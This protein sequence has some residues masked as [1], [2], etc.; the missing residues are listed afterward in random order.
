M[1]NDVSISLTAKD[2]VSAIL[3]QVSKAS[4]STATEIDKL[5][6]S[7]DTLSAAKVDLKTNLVQ[8]QQEAAEARKEFRKLGDS[9]SEQNYKDKLSELEHLEQ[10]YYAVSQSIKIVEKQQSA[11]A[12]SSH[13]KSSDTRKQELSEL[14]KLELQYYALSEGINTVEADEIALAGTRSK[15]YNRTTDGSNAFSTIGSIG[16]A[17]ATAGF[18]QMLSGSLSGAAGA[19]LG[20][21]FGT[22]NGSAVE[23]ILSSALSGASMGA[24]AGSMIGGPGIGTA[25]GAAAGTLIGAVSGGIEAATQ[26]FTEKDEAFKSYVQEQ[27]EGALEAQS[28][29]LTSGSSIA[30]SREQTQMAFAKALGGDEAA[31]AYLDQVREMATR[32]NYTYDEITAYTKQL[33]NSYAPDEI[34]DVLGDLSDA[35]AGLNLNSSDVS[36]W[37]SGLNRMRITDK[38]TLEYLNYFS[39]RGLNVYEALSKALGVQESAVQDLIS[40]GEVSGTQAADAILDYI[41]EQYGGLSDQLASSYGGLM[42]NLEDANADLQNAMGEGYNEAR[43]AG[44]QEQL[45]WMNGE[46]GE[47]MQQAYEKIGAFRASLENT[48]DQMER[49]ALTAVMSG[50]LPEEGFETQLGRLQEMAE[51]Y[52]N[53]AQVIAVS[54]EGSKAAQEAAATQG[55]LL[56]EAKVM[57]QNEYNASEGAQILLESQLQLAESVAADTSAD[58]TYWNTG[59]RQGQVYMNGIAS[60][61]R[62]IQLPSPQMPSVAGV[63]VSENIRDLYTPPAFRSEKSS[64]IG[65]N[66]VP[67]D[68]TLYLLHEGERV[69]TAREARAQDQ[70]GAGGVNIYMGG[71]YTVRQDSDISAIAEAVAARILRYRRI[72][73]T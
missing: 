4:Y 71:N 63:S 28:A 59:L 14:E 60:A 21:Y 10:Q 69:L 13:K 62:S 46:M 31:N 40:D 44:L 68:N 6:D 70:G 65:E 45:D 32:T 5:Q 57:A 56:E 12:S 49:D 47:S 11:L 41:G 58:E 18:G 66:R 72:A 30:G 37:V 39:E 20:S 7:L 43:K 25:V 42:G 38:A 26:K 35:T 19:F 52:A 15:I 8:V 61:I 17:L 24:A 3:K 27:T 22:S 33:L 29:A 34:L 50:A 2:K 67:R 73:R 53:A 16:S 55:M 1:P 64:A 51:E 54:P 48:R 9:V 36:L 23:S